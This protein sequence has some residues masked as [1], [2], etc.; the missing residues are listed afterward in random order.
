M[1]LLTYFTIRIPNILYTA[2]SVCQAQELY[3][4]IRY[5]VILNTTN[6]R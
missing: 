3:F 5:N 4:D 2:Y 6:Y 1:Y